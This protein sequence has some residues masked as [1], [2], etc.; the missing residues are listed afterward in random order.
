M[1]LAFQQRNTE[2]C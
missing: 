2:A 1:K